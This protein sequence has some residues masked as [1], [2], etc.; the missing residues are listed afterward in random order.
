MINTAGSSQNCLMV[1]TRKGSVR[2]MG[3]GVVQG[4]SKGS[5]WGLAV[6]RGWGAQVLSKGLVC[7]GVHKASYLFFLVSSLLKNINDFKS[8][9]LSR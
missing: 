4:L 3:G 8:T 1:G 2:G 6:G 5:V 7:G 9:T